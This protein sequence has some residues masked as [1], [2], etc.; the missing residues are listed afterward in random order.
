M[1]TIVIIINNIIHVILV[2]NP[3]ENSFKKKTTQPV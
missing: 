3:T 2:K 1:I